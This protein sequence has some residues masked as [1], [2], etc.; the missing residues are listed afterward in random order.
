MWRAPGGAHTGKKKTAQST[1]SSYSGGAS[2]LG[3]PL[4]AATAS[5]AE[6]DALAAAGMLL[7]SGIAVAASGDSRH[8]DPPQQ[9]RIAR[10]NIAAASG[11]TSMPPSTVLPPA[12]RSVPRTDHS[13]S[14]PQYVL[15]QSLAPVGGV[16]DIFALLQTRV[17]RMFVSPARAFDDHV[18]EFV[19]E[20]ARTTSPAGHVLL[21][22]QAPTDGASLTH[23]DDVTTVATA[24]VG[25]SESP[26]SIMMGNSPP[27]IEERED[28]GQFTLVARRPVKATSGS[29]ATG[30]AVVARRARQNSPQQLERPTRVRAHVTP[31]VPH[32]IETRLAV[33][34]CSA[35]R[36]NHRAGTATTGIT[37]KSLSNSDCSVAGG[38]GGTIATVARKHDQLRPIRHTLPNVTALTQGGL[39]AG[40]GGFNV[41]VIDAVQQHA[42]I[43]APLPNSAAA[44]QSPLRSWPGTTAGIGS[45]GSALPLVVP[46][47]RPTS[48]V[49]HEAAASTNI[50]T[51]MEAQSSL[52]A[53]AAAAHDASLRNDYA[54]DPVQSSG[55]VRSS[56]CEGAPQQPL[57]VNP[58][59]SSRAQRALRNLNPAAAE[60]RPTP[61]VPVMEA[62]AAAAGYAPADTRALNGVHSGPTPT[63]QLKR[64]VSNLAAK[65]RV[66][67]DANRVPAKA[68]ASCDTISGAPQAAADA[69][70]ESG[71]D[72]DDG[73]ETEEEGTRVEDSPNTDASDGVAQRGALSPA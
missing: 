67:S 23:A 35:V 51:S 36:T 14:R 4:T 61:P 24:E 16:S 9:P 29:T 26:Q 13:P 3:V 2:S 62:C 11:F 73:D 45:R 59:A 37:A 66:D 55:V 53:N 18:G 17:D 64:L 22:A 28:D 52:D 60:W 63:E 15:T 39:V 71:V 68:T 8:A 56:D 57:L 70:C 27:T 30:A 25:R 72:D 7:A 32:A 5:G 58:S 46:A 1:G 21:V 19:D 54:A 10:R 42:R 38:T 40:K 41:D 69:R 20:N 43:T 48:H 65:S 31:A 47:G 50:V 44:T 33:E 34:D 49:N 6:V 12:P